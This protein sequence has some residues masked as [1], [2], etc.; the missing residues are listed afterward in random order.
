MAAIANLAAVILVPS[1]I[2]PDEKI[3]AEEAGYIPVAAAAPG[4]KKSRGGGGGGAVRIDLPGDEAEDREALLGE[5][6][7]DEDLEVGRI[8]ERRHL[9]KAS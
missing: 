8:N 2:R 6:P 4:G 9:A 5:E 1:H 7:N 3:Q